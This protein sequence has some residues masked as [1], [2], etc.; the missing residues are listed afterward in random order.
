M[1]KSLQ[2]ISP[3]NF[4][5]FSRTDRAATIKALRLTKRGL[6]NALTNTL[7]EESGDE[8]VDLSEYITK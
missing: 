7:E 8:L 1:L 5:Y 3:N 4:Y 6:L 2:L